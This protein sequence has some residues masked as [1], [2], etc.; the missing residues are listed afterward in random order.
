M[1]K[2]LYVQS[3]F[4]E[5]NIFEEKSSRENFRTVLGDTTKNEENQKNLYSGK[6][7]DKELDRDTKDGFHKKKVKLDSSKHSKNMTQRQSL[8]KAICVKSKKTKPAFMKFSKNS[9]DKLQ[10]TF[11]K[12]KEYKMLKLKLLAMEIPI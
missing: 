6:K 7:V 8:G 12:K 4:I 5:K 10:I 11:G 2:V 3:K 1:L 9:K